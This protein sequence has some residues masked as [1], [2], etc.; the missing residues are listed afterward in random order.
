MQLATVNVLEGLITVKFMSDP[1]NPSPASLSLAASVII[2]VQL[3]IYFM[4]PSFI[5]YSVGT[6]LDLI[7]ARLSGRP[8]SLLR[9][10]SLLNFIL[11]FAAIMNY[12][13][14]DYNMTSGYYPS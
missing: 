10:D 9:M 8:I 12:T 6:L 11:F 3:F 2:L 14:M 4:L 5:L 1:V 13:V 7:F